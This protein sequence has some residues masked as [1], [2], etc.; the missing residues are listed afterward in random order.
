MKMAIG[1]LPPSKN[2]IENTNSAIAMNVKKGCRTISFM[3]LFLSKKE[4]K[5]PPIKGIKFLRED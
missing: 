1:F 2:I 3:F 4:A 5:I